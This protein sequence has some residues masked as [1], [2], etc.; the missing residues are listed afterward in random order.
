M[1]RPMMIARLA[2][3]QWII[4]LSMENQLTGDS[5]DSTLSICLSCW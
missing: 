2:S 4:L 1:D 3:D 5:G